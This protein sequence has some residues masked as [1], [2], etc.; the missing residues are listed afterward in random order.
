MQITDE[1]VNKLEAW[2]GDESIEAFA[3]YVNKYGDIVWKKGGILYPLIPLKENMEELK[4]CD[5]MSDHDFDDSWIEIV[6]KILIK[7]KLIV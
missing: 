7:R 4:L 5:I 2:L 3:F 1:I 6:K